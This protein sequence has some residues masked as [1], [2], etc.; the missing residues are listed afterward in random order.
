[1][2]VKCLAFKLYTTH[3]QI[4]ELAEVCKEDRIEPWDYAN[5]ALSSIV[6]LL[7]GFSQNT[8]RPEDLH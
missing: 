7:D 3:K 8:P 6:E 2:Y 4:K 1:M 5:Q